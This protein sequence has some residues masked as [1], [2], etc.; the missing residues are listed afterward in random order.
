[1]SMAF[2]NYLFFIQMFCSSD[3]I[4]EELLK[5]IMLHGKAR[6]EDTYQSFYARLLEMKVPVHILCTLPQM[7]HSS[8]L[9]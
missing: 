6:S 3:C 2:P 1:M 7:A 4:E 5:T 9:I 8:R